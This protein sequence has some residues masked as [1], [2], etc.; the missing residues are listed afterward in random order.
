[1]VKF[2]R[3]HLKARD[4]VET[5]RWYVEHLGAK[6]LQD[7]RDKGNHHILLDIGNVE[8]IVTQPP[9]AES[10]P[11]APLDPYIGLEHFGVATDD[12]DG[13]LAGME[14]KGVEII[15]RTPPESESQ[16]AFV[17]APDGVRFELVQE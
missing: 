6:E 13:V 9:D 4:V 2:Y 12:L 14:G 8:V 16:Y 5:A 15:S 11:G 10:L 17:R 7:Y 3:I 1:M